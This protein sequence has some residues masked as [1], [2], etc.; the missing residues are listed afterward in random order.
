MVDLDTRENI[1]TSSMAAYTDDSAEMWVMEGIQNEFYRLSGDVD[2]STTIH[3][4]KLIW[5]YFTKI[6]KYT[7]KQ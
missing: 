6:L 2:D 5:N 3:R 1:D 4:M 7:F